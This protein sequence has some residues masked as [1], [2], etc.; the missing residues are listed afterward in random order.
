MAGVSR[1]RSA[2]TSI[3]SIFALL[4]SA[5]SLYETVLRRPELA[6][7]VG[8]VVHYTH[9][10][11]KEVL[12]IPVNIANGGARDGTVLSLALEATAAGRPKPKTFYSAYVVNAG[13]FLRSKLERSPT[14]GLQSTKQRPKVPFA[15]LTIAGRGSYS[16]TIL[17]IPKG[18]EFPRLITEAGEFS[19]TL[20][21][22]TRLDKALGWLDGL[23]AVQ[24]RPVSFRVRAGNFSKYTVRRG[25]TIEL[26][27]AS[28]SDAELP[29]NPISELK[30]IKQADETAN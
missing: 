23:R 14:G 3:V 19:M 4:F 26:K 24:P 13:Y 9:D 11:G 20:T 17:F 7:Y 6:I 8:P 22:N 21:P 12:A 5:V 25:D 27:D 18:K 10:N 15:P 2:A 28:W 16:G 30:K 29:P 1:G